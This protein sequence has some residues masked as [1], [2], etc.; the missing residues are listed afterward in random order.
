M[1]RPVLIIEAPELDEKTANSVQNF[2]HELVLAF[3]SHYC[4]QLRG[5]RSSSCSLD[6][7]PTVGIE[8]PF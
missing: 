4:L 8:D 2:L 3:E 5:K 1:D 7:D 6:F